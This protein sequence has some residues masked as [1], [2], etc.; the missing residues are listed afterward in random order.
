V[1]EFEFEYESGGFWHF[2]Q[3]PADSPT[4]FSRIQICFVARSNLIFSDTDKSKNNK[5]N[6]WLRVMTQTLRLLVP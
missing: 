4:D 1:T 2:P 6:C 5:K 3:N